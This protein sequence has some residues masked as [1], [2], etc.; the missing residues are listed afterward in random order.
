MSVRLVIDQMGREVK[1]PERPKRIV[2]LVPSIT[3]L[4]FDLGLGNHVVGVTRFCVHPAEARQ[5]AINIGG[6]KDL[7][8]GRIAELQPDL[9]IGTKEE[10]TR[11]HIEQ[12]QENFPVWLGDV[13][14]IEEAIN[15]IT[16]VGDVCGKPDEGTEMANRVRKAFQTLNQQ[17][18]DGPMK[19]AY[20]IWK[21]PM[22]VSGS[23]NFIDSVITKMGWHNIFSEHPN[24][25]PAIDYEE[26]KA[27]QPDLILLSSEP[28]PFNKDHVNEFSALL[29]CPTLLVDGE[30][31]SWYGSRMLKMPD[32]LK[33]LKKEVLQY[34]VD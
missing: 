13:Q 9:I 4:L 24:R 3:E 7:K 2:S 17:S 22:M 10:N 19:V 30:M 29:Q 16:D 6:T 1:L 5:N 21:D 32:Y 14:T 11:R 26:L 15:L 12:L 28:Y 25:Y 8:I 34:N 31:F 18:S 33:T 27:A 23:H 20:L